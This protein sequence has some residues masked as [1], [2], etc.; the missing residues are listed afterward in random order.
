MQ[1]VL[2]NVQLLFCTFTWGKI[3]GVRNLQWKLL[4]YRKIPKN[5]DTQTFAV[6]TLKFE[7]G[8]L[9]IVSSN[10]SKRSRCNGKQC[11]TR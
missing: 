4:S 10:A 1:S 11:R 8:G 2:L 6:I 9:T 7:Q 5:S 3:N